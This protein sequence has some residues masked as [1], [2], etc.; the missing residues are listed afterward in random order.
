MYSTLYRRG[1]HKL[2]KCVFP[3]KNG[4][5]PK[6]SPIITIYTVYIECIHNIRTRRILVSYM[7]I[8]NYI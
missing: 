4:Q 5:Q 2:H 8:Y 6:H 7:Y 3:H 1:E